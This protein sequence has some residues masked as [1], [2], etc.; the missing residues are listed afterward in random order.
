MTFFDLFRIQIITMTMK[1]RM[2]NTTEYRKYISIERYNIFEAI[3]F[4]AD[5][6]CFKP[7]D[8]HWMMRL[9]PRLIL[10][11]V[12]LWNERNLIAKRDIFKELRRISIHDFLLQKSKTITKTKVS[13]SKGEFCILRTILLFG[14]FQPKNRSVGV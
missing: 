1:I 2:R 7:D 10:P 5:S 6:I 11:K 13:K 12:Q 8:R 14:W 4:Y 3:A 9:L